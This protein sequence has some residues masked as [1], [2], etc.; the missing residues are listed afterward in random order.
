MKIGITTFHGPK[1]IFSGRGCAAKIPRGIAVVS[2]SVYNNFAGLISRINSEPFLFSRG[3]ADGEPC[4]DDVLRL[5]AILRKKISASPLSPVIAIGGGSVIDAVKLA[6]CIASRHGAPSSPGLSFEEIYCGKIKRDDCPRLIAV[7]TTAGTGTGVS[8]VAVVTKKD[9]VKRGIASPYLIA[10]E[11]YY[12][13]DLIDTLPADI[14]AA[15]AMDALT[16]AV[17]AYVSLIENIPADTM[18]LKAAELI[19]KN[20]IA[21]YKG[22]ASARELVHYGNMMA[23]QAFSNARLGLCHALSHLIG[24]RFGIPHG[25]IN[26]S[27]AVGDRL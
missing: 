10:D 3:A 20:I 5:S 11:A 23:G 24:G 21:G 19:G 18:A 22:G 4:E 8:N 27:F 9:N 6:L 25:R 7:E 26:H 12:D 2:P 15:S 17:E 14:F 1:F 13:A 16:H